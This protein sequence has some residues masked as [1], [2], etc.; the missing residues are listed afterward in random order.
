MI[1]ELEKDNELRNVFYQIFLLIM[2]HLS[3]QK[4]PQRAMLKTKELN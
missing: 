2:Q 1:D 4:A 3:M